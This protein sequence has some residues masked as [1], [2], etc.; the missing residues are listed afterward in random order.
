MEHIAWMTQG[1]VTHIVL[2]DWSNGIYEAICAHVEFASLFIFAC[3]SIKSG[4]CLCR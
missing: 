4:L 1:Q 2:L 3:V